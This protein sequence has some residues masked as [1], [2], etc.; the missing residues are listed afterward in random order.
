LRPTPFISSRPPNAL[1]LSGERRAVSMRIQLDVPTPLVGCSG[2]LASIFELHI[3]RPKRFD[4]PRERSQQ[5]FLGVVPFLMI[6]MH[7]WIWNFREPT[8]TSADAQKYH[9]EKIERPVRVD[10]VVSIE[11]DSRV[12]VMR[13]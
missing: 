2:P 9:F 11:H 13:P 12:I 3:R 5:L 4:T 7:M 8:R 6:L 10:E 1:P